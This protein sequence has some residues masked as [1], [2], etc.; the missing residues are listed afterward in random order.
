MTKT[1][2]VLV[3]LFLAV[4][5]F[6]FAGALQAQGGG[7]LKGKV[8]DANEKLPMPT[9]KVTISGTRKYALTG[10]DGTFVIE[11]IPPGAY[12]VVFEIAGFI[13]ETRKNVTIAAEQTA[14]LNVSLMMG[15]AH[16]VTV[17]ARRAV[18]SLQKVPQNVTVLTETRLEETP[19]NNILQALNNVPG[20][21]VETASGN[22][23]LG[24]FMS[25]DGYGDTYIRKMV[26]GVDVGEVVNNWSMLNSFPEE[27]IDQIEVLK[28]GSSSV[29]GSNM[30]GIINIITKRPQDLPRP[31]I[32]LKST[33]SHFGAMDFQGANAIGVPGD[34]LDYSANI[35]GNIKK[36][37]YTFGYDGIHNDGF[38]D[39][40]K[41]KNSS[42]F[43]KLNYNFNSNTFLDFLYNRNV[44]NS[45][46]LAYLYLPDMLGTDEPYYW[47]YK[48]DYHATENVASLK[49]QTNISPA[50][51]LESQLKY[52]RSTFDGT[53][54]YLAGSAFQ[55][56]AGTID[57]SSYTDQKL[58]FTL[59]GSYNPSEALSIVSGVD[60]YRIMADFTHYI[61]DQPKI[62]VDSV[63]PFVNMEYRIGNL[64]LHLGARYDYDSAFGQQLSPSVGA[65]FN[66]SKATLFRINVAR[67]FSPPPLWYTLG[68]SYMEQI[69][70]NPNLKPERAWAYSAGFESQELRYVYV[71]VSLYYHRMKDG[72]VMVPASTEGQFTWGN[73]AKFL[74]EGYEGEFGF[75]TPIGLTGYV[76]TDYNHHEDVT[77]AVTEIVSW[78]PTRTYKAGLKYRNDKLGLFAN[79]RARWIWWNMDPGTA[80][81]LTPNDKKWIFDFRISKG[82]NM[83]RN[84]H[85]RVFLDIYNLTNQ[86]YWDRS[87]FPN[88][89]RW[90]QIGLEVSY[91]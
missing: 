25:I 27:M 82:F 12:T 79:L 46:D 62:Y 77:G 67:T 50:F 45:Q 16:E 9:V 65:T 78:I 72:I 10:P 89:R 20:V 66:L 41:E 54:D 83:V 24:T 56:P 60:Y 55:P 58:G 44:M 37:G 86:A 69:Q 84:T 90:G 30:G 36:F 80:S 15:F 33:Y 59:K 22:T 3:V 4:F 40:G 31:E 70:P 35:R 34:N 21:D 43:S 57:L 88:P 23:V 81:L 2:R 32:T 63:A 29:W 42:F 19:Q 49:F 52:N 76:G 39:Y 51:N 6:R 18:E 74:R 5:L 48:A 64:G 8:I 17:T 53:T 68:V 28:G 26:D 87:D 75:L 14:E 91:K 11:N 38:V 61:A 85:L 71:K 13:T 73:I 47:N 7:N 1:L